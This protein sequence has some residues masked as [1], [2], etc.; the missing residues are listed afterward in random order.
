M[1][2]ETILSRQAGM[3]SRAQVLATGASPS[4]INRRVASGAWMRVHPGVYLAT[5]RE[6][7]TDTRLHAAILWAGPAATISGVRAAWWHRLWADS[8]AMIDLTVPQGW[9]RSARPG[10]RVRRRDLAPVDRVAVRGIWVTAL[11]LTVLEAAV[12][13]GRPGQALLDRALQRGV[14]LDEL[15]QAQCR[16]LG[17]YGSAAAAELLRVAGDRAASEAERLATALLRGAHIDGWQCGYRIGDYQA[18]I[19]FPASKLV[20]EIDGWAW[21]A[22]IERFQRDRR[23]QNALVLAGWTVLRFTWQDLTTRPEAVVREVRKALGS[24]G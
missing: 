19:A 22:D 15:C 8:S 20:I 7:T 9:K 10:L 5:D 11:P 21:H 2:I 12:E 14:T 13:L 3:I 18:D 1:T 16:N 24:R 6:L 17:R 4:M 23:R